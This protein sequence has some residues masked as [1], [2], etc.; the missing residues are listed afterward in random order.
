MRPCPESC[1]TATNRPTKIVGTLVGSTLPLISIGSKWG[2]RFYAET[3]NSVT[4]ISPIALP[5]SLSGL[6][7]LRHFA[8]VFLQEPEDAVQ[9]T[10][11]IYDGHTLLLYGVGT[12][13]AQGA[14]LCRC[15]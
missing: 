7:P 2:V 13:A 10:L 4:S 15:R 14:C 9:M 1:W 6:I 5:N 12:N 3:I 11:H 8:L